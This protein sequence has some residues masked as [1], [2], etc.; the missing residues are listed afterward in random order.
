MRITEMLGKPV[1]SADTGEKAGH[2]EEVLLDAS[3]H[4]AVG[5][6]VSDGVLSHQRVLPFGDVQ[7]VGADTLIVRTVSTICDATA[8]IAEGRAAHRSS[9]LRGKAVV[10]SDGVRAGRIDDLVAEDDTG[11]V[12]ALELASRKRAARRTIVLVLDDLELTHEVVVVRPAALVHS[13]EP[14]RAKRR[15]AS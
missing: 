5:V 15:Q 1:V 12:T 6:L 11:A 13:N 7:T 3:H 8:W 2:V 10:T 4:H 9:E 14:R